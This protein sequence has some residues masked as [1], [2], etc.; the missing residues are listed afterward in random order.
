MERKLTVDE[1]NTDSRF[2]PIRATDR[3]GSNRL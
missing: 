3:S 1:K 2:E